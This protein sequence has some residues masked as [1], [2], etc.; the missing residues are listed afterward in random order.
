[1]EKSFS[2]TIFVL[3]FCSCNNSVFIFFK[4]FVVWP[5][6][7]CKFEQLSRNILWN[8]VYV[9]LIKSSFIF[10]YVYLCGIMMAIISTEIYGVIWKINI[11]QYKVFLHRILLIN[12]FCSHWIFC[13]CFNVVTTCGLFACCT[14]MS[15]QG[16]RDRIWFPHYKNHYINLNVKIKWLVRKRV[17][18]G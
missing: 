5:Y 3:L 4:H 16:H 6:N 2:I 11:T 15:L 18:Y 10:K 8:V 17:F 7:L 1:M 9:F 14:K 12:V 13:G